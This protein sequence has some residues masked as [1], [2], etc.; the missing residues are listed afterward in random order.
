MEAWVV[1]AGGEGQPDVTGD[2]WKYRVAAIGWGI[3]DLSQASNRE[4]I[5][6]KLQFKNSGW[7]NSKMGNITG[8]IHRFVLEIS[9][10]DLIVTPEPFGGSDV[11]IGYCAGPYEYQPGLIKDCDDARKVNWQKRITRGSLSGPLRR[12][13]VPGLTVYNISKHIE[14]IQNLL[15]KTKD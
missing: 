13:L 5:E 10:G 2:F 8:S 14:E 3:G 12:S 15:I 11:L 4:E 1:R 6:A 9:V 7:S